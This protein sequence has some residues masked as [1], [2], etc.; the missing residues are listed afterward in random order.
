MSVSTVT[1]RNKLRKA[2]KHFGETDAEIVE[3]KVEEQIQL[4]KC[5]KAAEMPDT[6]QTNMGP[7]TGYIVDIV[8]NMSQ[9]DNKVYAVQLILTI[10]SKLYY[11]FNSYEIV[12]KDSWTSVEDEEYLNETY[13]IVELEN[14]P[15]ELFVM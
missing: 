10:D 15:K 2:Y 8:S 4:M 6:I 9:E 13:K 3:E 12:R 7:M 1:I 5:L 14:V 11:L